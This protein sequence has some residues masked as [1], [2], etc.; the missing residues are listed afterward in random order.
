MHSLT[1]ALD[2]DEWPASCP[3]HF[4]P[5]ERGPGTHWLGVWARPRAS[6]Y[7]VVKRRIP[8]P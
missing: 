6:V 4:T 5:R 8:S 1:F 7:T 3:G 2:G